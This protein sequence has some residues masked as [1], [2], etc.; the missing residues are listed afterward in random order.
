[1]SSLVVFFQLDKSIIVGQRRKHEV[2]NWRPVVFVKL[3]AL[4]ITVYED[5]TSVINLPK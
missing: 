1:M 3:K 2:N 4:M 5:V